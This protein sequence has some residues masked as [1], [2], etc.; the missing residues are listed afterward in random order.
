MSIDIDLKELSARESERVEWKENGDDIDIAKSITKT[1]SA[2]ANDISNLGGGYVVCGAK[3][4]RDEHGFPKLIYT[5][6]SSSRL[7]EIEGKVMQ[8]CREMVNPAIVPIVTELL[9]P[10]DEATR[11]LVFT[12]PA[13]PDVHTYRDKSGTACY[14]RMS[15]ETREA[16]NGV[17]MQ[18][19]TQKNKIEFFDKRVNPQATVADIELLVM[20][21]YFQEMGEEFMERPLEDYL[22]DVNQMSAYIPPLF[23]KTG[24]DNILRPRNF[25]LLM[26][27]KRESIARLFTEA[28]TIVSIYPGKDR[29]EPTAERHT[30]T[31]NIV[32]Q[33]RRA[34]ELLHTQSYT[35]FDKTSDKPNQE[36]YPLRVLQ[37]AVVNAIVHRD[38]EIPAPN[39]ITVFSDRVEI[40]SMGTLHWSVDKEKFM[41]GKANPYW[42][43]QSL[44]YLFNK[45][46][47]A[48]AEGQGLPTIFRTME[49]EGFPKPVFEIGSQN[50][51]CTIPAH[52]RHE[53]I[54]DQLAG[55]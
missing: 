52:P 3:E 40:N 36:K 18:L 50:I 2:F 39:R 37:E 6:L 10:E 17:F 54:R 43:N 45:L 26:F 8:Y 51:I 15:R 38:Y 29:S 11:L 16:K 49:R 20:K 34:I 47:L 19:R 44:A 7:K 30:I 9:N 13:T 4:G 55:S 27:G 1:I 42:R 35:A 46:H 24:I 41:Q 48:Q 28:Y 25:T 32:W 53:Q 22:S 12:V 33:A 31:G 14:V 5:G 21:E 23:V